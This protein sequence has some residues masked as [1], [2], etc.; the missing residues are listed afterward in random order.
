L[1]DK[2]KFMYKV[3]K[4]HNTLYNSTHEKEKRQTKLETRVISFSCIWRGLC[5]GQQGFL[6][7]L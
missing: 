3:E 7:C 4:G 1:I 5:F 2:E 6:K